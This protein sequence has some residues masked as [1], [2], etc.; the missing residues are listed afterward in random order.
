MASALLDTNAVSDL[1]RDHPQMKS[2]TANFGGQLIT[3]PVVCGEIRYG[4]ERMPAGKKRHDLEARAHAV[5]TTLP[6]PSLTTHVAQVYG[7]IKSELEAKGVNLGENDLWMAATALSLG[8]ILVTR[9]QDFRHVPG[10]TVEDW[11]T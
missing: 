2:R 1:M 9:D 3:S 4:L 11:T 5:L 7:R 10:L 6:C 8:V